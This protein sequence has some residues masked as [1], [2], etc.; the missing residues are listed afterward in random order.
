MFD[1]KK[2]DILH[3]N[4]ITSRVVKNLLFSVRKLSFGHPPKPIGHT[5]PNKKN[6]QFTIACE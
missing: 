5:N 2:P 6:Y 3:Q 1:S 4:G